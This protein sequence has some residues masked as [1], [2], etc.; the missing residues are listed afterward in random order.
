MLPIAP[1]GRT[2]HHSTRV[3]FGA[4]ALG[5]MSEHR[6]LA[7][8]DLIAAHGVNHI[9]TAA[10]YGAS[11]DRLAPW[12]RAHR[13]EVFLATKTGE[14]RGA[15]AR[16]ELERSLVRLEVDS[17]DLIQMHNLVEDDEWET[18][19]GPGG[20]YEALCVARDEGLVGAVG[21]TGHGLRIAGM[22]RRSLE[23]ADLD[24]VLLPVNHSLLSM[25]DYA[26]EV[27]ALLELCEQRG[28]AVQTIKSIARRRWPDGATSGRRS[29]YE[30][31][32]DPGAIARAVRFVLS[33]QR[34]FLNTTSDATLL[35]HV[36]EAA[37]GDLTRPTEADLAADVEAEAI[38]PLFDG[39]SLER[40]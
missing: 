3:I 18:A 23:R 27:E 10:S 9:D 2:G 21:V 16:A 29:W 24:S 28:V 6:A 32:T 31:L 33:D 8:L 14:R 22:H 40:I 36:L 37:A 4:A 12:L 13:H 19:F 39:A 25:P 38:T 20:A 7:T 5:G 11:E 1:F 34:L 26:A 15:A 17:V 30:P 35:P